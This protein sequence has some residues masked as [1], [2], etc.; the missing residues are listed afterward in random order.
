MPG[1]SSVWKQNPALWAGFRPI[2]L[3]RLFRQ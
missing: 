1:K 2:I 3:D